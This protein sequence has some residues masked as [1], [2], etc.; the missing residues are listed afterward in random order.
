MTPF[1][2]YNKKTNKLEGNTIIPS[3]CSKYLM[4]D[5]KKCKRHYEKTIQ[6][7][8]K[9]FITCPYGFTTYVSNHNRIYTSLIIDEKSTNS[10]LKNNLEKT[11]EKINKMNH[12]K[13]DQITKM[14]DM[15]EQLEEDNLTFNYC[16]HDLRNMG[17]YFYG[18]TET[19]KEDYEDLY[20]EDDNIKALCILYDIIN[21][22][23][24]CI[25]GIKEQNY[26]LEIKKLHP[27]IKKIS[28]LMQF[29][30]KYKNVKITFNGTQ[31]NEVYMSKN[32]YLAIFLILENA[33]K[34][35]PFNSEIYINF[36]DQKE[37]SQVEITNSC[38]HLPQE[39]IP[40]LTERGYRGSNSSPNGNGLGLALAKEI[41]DA[42]NAFFKID[43]N[44]YSKES[45]LF[46]VTFR[47]YTNK[48]KKK[49]QEV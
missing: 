38:K 35:S 11:K 36:E 30:A 17:N 49:T 34:Y 29:Q 48:R 27:Q 15:F 13:E 47:L 1:V 8:I 20:N 43:V 24:D 46:K 21:Y 41:F 10:K 37:Y 5:C 28:I 7:N 16:V 25:E 45:S 44:D 39:E 4:D 19:I 12:Y 42:S 22:R 18:I 23:V 33:V 9:G 14:I 31:E 40:L 3:F 32:I 2:E 26:K 6:E